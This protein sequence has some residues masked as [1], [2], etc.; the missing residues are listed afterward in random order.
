MWH[1]PVHGINAFIPWYRNSDKDFLLLT[2]GFRLINCGRKQVALLILS[3]V[4]IISLVPSIR[5]SCYEWGA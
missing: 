5:E 4:R 1:N 2:A 3:F